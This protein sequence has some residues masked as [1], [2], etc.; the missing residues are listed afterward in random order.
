MNKYNVIVENK[1]TGERY[2]VLSGNGQGDIFIALAALVKAA[3]AHMHYFIQE[4]M[5]IS[6]FYLEEYPE[7]TDMHDEINRD[8]TMLGLL[9]TLDAGKDAYTYIG[10][11]DSVVRERCFKKLAELLGVSY[12][13]RIELQGVSCLKINYD[14]WSKL[15]G[16]YND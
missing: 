13:Q 15:G 10:V 11:Y 6:Q 12:L 1:I 7:D 3:P 9:L 14:K 5:R 4:D 16:N 8:A 2:P